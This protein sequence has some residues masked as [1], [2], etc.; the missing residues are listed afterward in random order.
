MQASEGKGSDKAAEYKCSV[1]HRVSKSQREGVVLRFA[2]FPE[3][4]SGNVVFDD[5]LHRASVMEAMEVVETSGEGAVRDF[6]ANRGWLFV[7][8]STRFS[9]VL[10]SVY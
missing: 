6:R 9:P 3:L 5:A 7:F 2:T 4:N 8:L 1:G 10:G